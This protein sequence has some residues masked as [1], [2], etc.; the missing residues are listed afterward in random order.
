MLYHEHA[1]GQTEHEAHQVSAD[2][3]V[4]VTG[5]GKCKQGNSADDRSE[6]ERPSV[7]GHQPSAPDKAGHQAQGG[8]HRRRRT[9]RPMQR[10][11]QQ[12]IRSVGNEGSQHDGQ[13]RGAGSEKPSGKQAKK[14]AEAHIAYQVLEVEVQGQCGK[15]PPDLTVAKQRAVHAAGGQPVAPERG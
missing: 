12:R 4:F 6:P 15:G 3:R 2:I 5:P 13:P 1:G 10:V 9:N 11:E 14:T 7:L 8:K